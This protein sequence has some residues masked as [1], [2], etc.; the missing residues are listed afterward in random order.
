ML[1]HYLFIF[2]MKIKIK[3]FSPCLVI[4]F[5]DDSKVL[6]LIIRNCLKLN[7]LRKELIQFNKANTNNNSYYKFEEQKL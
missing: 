3:D 1:I 2:N 4:D 6:F 5:K 7:I